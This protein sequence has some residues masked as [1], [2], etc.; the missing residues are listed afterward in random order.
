M[1]PT[2]AGEYRLIQLNEMEEFRTEA[3]EN[4]RIYKE[5]TKAWHDRRLKDRKFSPGQLVLLFNSRLKLFPGKLRSRWSGPF[6]I[7]KVL[8]YGVL[9]LMGNDD[10][11][12]F[13]VNASQVKPYFGGVVNRD[14][15]TLMMEDA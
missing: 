2:A 13:K 12:K 8:P 5:K 10:S 6:K 3:Y 14:P 1:D 15:T 9:E 4:A 7:T 11:N